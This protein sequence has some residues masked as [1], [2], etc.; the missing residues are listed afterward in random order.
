MYY[1]CARII[2]GDEIGDETDFVTKINQ[3]RKIM[4]ELIY[5]YIAIGFVSVLAFI[6]APKYVKDR[7]LLVKH[8]NIAKKVFNFAKQFLTKK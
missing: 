7:E 2:I 8:W 5:V 4:N 6:L 3:N 1:I